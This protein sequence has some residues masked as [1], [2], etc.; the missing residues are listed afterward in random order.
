MQL[1]SLK[2]YS[3]IVEAE[4]V[5]DV[6]KQAS[7]HVILQKDGISGITSLTPGAEIF[8]QEKDWERAYSL[9]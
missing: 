4:L 5:V 7:I 2:K 1:V 3:S 8:I 9:L 6:L